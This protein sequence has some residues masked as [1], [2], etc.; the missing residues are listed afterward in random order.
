M[1]CDGNP[2]SSH[3][4]CQSIQCNIGEHT[5]NV[6]EQGT[7][8]FFLPPG[9]F[10]K[11]SDVVEGVRGSSTRAAAKVV[12]QEEVMYFSSMDEVLHNACQEYLGHCVEQGD[13]LVCIGCHV[14]RLGGLPEYNCN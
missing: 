7:D 2:P 12:A 3:V 1:Y 14:I 11:C 4:V 6:E 9:I 8:N 13:G 5:F 10:D